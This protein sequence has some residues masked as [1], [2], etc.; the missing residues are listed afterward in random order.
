VTGLTKLLPVLSMVRWWRRFL[1]DCMQGFFRRSIQQKIHYR[2]CLKNQM[3]LITRINR[4][5]CQYCRY[6]AA[7]VGSDW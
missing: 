1:V 6:V 4:N 2:A 5:R 7:V 3:C